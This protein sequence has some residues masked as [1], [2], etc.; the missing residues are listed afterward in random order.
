M[1]VSSFFKLQQMILNS[2]HL[3]LVGE[4]GQRDVVPNCCVEIAGKNLAIFLFLFEEYS[5]TLQQRGFI[6]VV[7]GEVY[8]RKWESKFMWVGGPNSKEDT[9]ASSE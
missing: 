8:P 7:R 1:D 6:S 5:C 2:K 3:F 9:F 4:G